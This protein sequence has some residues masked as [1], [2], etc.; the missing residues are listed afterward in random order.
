VLVS[1]FKTKCKPEKNMNEKKSFLP[2]MIPFAM[3][4]KYHLL[5][6]LLMCCLIGSQH[7]KAQKPILGIPHTNLVHAKSFKQFYFLDVGY[8]SFSEAYRSMPDVE[9]IQKRPHIT[10]AYLEGS[11]IENLGFGFFG[12]RLNQRLNILEYNDVASLSLSV[13]MQISYGLPGLTFFAPVFL[14][15][16]FFR[17]S[18]KTELDQYGFNIG[19]GYGRIRGLAIVDD[20]ND[21]FESIT[22]DKGFFLV[23]G[24][25]TFNS[26]FWDRPRRIDYWI[27]LGPRF[28]THA[29]DKRVFANF[30]F[31]IA[32]TTMF[33][34]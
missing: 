30:Y 2:A 13:P 12:V 28:I 34:L 31:S 11:F 4:L 21:H 17:N 6:V 22:S 16:N 15:T 3:L 24:G 20:M 8:L 18:T 14:Q 5:V 9:Y 27:G 10:E 7:L 33:I 23:N 32:Y 19:I 25:L 26:G 29:G 1:S